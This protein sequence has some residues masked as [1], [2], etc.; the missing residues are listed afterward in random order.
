MDYTE[1][2]K[3]MKKDY[4]I[5]APDMFPIH[6]KLITGI[7]EQYGYRIEIL[8]YTGKK[9]LDTG[10]KYVHNDMCYPAVC[11]LGQLITAITSGDYDPHK[12]A[13]MHFQTRG[14]C[15]ASNYIKLLR[16]ALDNMGYGYIP[17][18]SLNFTGYERHRGFKMSPVMI[19]RGLISLLYGD[20]LMLLKNQV[21]PYEV[22][23]GEAA[24][25]VDRWAEELCSQY[26][27]HRGLTGKSIRKNLERIA[28]DFSR[29]E[30]VHKEKIKVGIVGEIYVKYAPFGN[31]DLE[32]FLESEDC[33][34]MVPG[35]LGFFE[36]GFSNPASDRRLY[37]GGFFRTLF[38]NIAL[39]ALEGTEKKMLDVLKKYPQFVSPSHFSELEKK[40]DVVL[41]HGVKMGE[42]WYLP[43]EMAELI[44]LGYKNI[45]CAQPFGCLPNHIVGKG[46]VRHIK[47]LYPDANICQ[48]D[49]DTGASY[50]NQE[51]RIKLM[52]AVAKENMAGGAESVPKTADTRVLTGVGI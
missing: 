30:I 27:R 49:Y 17:V 8:K 21:Q 15:R 2:T 32:K 52:L 33:E 11:T 5:L 22:K 20:M 28:A 47:E 42:G 50:E 38:G 12:V 10:L 35:A 9:V 36:Y 39:K 1:F 3:R 25:L 37:G 41:S 23:K 46:V 13:M 40:T 26:R 4:T 6:M 14:G 19:Y 48:V 29:I 45:V 16:K 44:E 31:N 7:F 51:N 43:A 18:I 24:Q 34:V